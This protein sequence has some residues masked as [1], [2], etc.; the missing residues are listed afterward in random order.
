MANNPELDKLDM[1]APK[2]ATIELTTEAVDETKLESI[3]ELNGKLNNI[4]TA[5]GQMY[6]RRR[7]LNDELEKVE[8]GFSRAEEDFKTFNAELKS[9]LDELE[10]EFPAGRLDLQNGTITYQAGLKGYQDV[11]NSLEQ[12]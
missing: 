5:F 3:R 7:E 11:Q 8:E 12:E 1:D 10:K 6:L 2:T 9:I 4:I